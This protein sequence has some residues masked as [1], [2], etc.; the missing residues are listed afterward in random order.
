[1]IRSWLRTLPA[2]DFSVVGALDYEDPANAFIPA[3]YE[4]VDWLCRAMGLAVVD[5][6]G[7][8]LALT[9][10]GGKLVWRRLGYEPA[11]AIYLPGIAAGTPAR[12]SDIATLVHITRHFEEY[13][14]VPADAPEVVVS[15][16]MRG[17]SRL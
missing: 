4:A 11:Y 7:D 2:N 14:A 17:F 16:S 10:L 9:L 12:A 8:P 15:P 13:E 6:A 3:L 1:M 5:S